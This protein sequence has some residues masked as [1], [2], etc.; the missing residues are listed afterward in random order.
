MAHTRQYKQREKAAAAALAGL[1]ARCCSAA[2]REG[3]RAGRFLTRRIT[4]MLVPHS[5]SRAVSVQTNAF[6]LFAGGVLCVALVS[7][8]FYFNRGAAWR[9]SEIARL[10]RENREMRASIDGLRGENAALLQTAARF[11]SALSKSLSQA[12]I[13]DGTVDSAPLGGGISGLFRAGTAALGLGRKPAEIRTLTAYLENAIQPVEQFGRALALH[14]ALLSDIPSVWPIKNG[15]GYMSMKFGRNTHPVTG[16]LYLHKG[17][18][19]STHRRGDPITATANGQVV[20]VGNNSWFGNYI[21]IEH[22]YGFQ[23]LYAHMDTVRAAKGQNVSQRDIIGTIGETGLAVGP[24][25]HYEV[26]IGSDIVDPEPYVS[27]KPER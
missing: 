11:Q 25:L 5:Q 8:F 10:A 15:L 1:F 13:T 14:G 18:D 3:E 24:H 27:I 22:K 16:I 9:N 4:V 6:A 19:I 23:T 17:L 21:L 12:G 26:H 2:G 7:S 20:N